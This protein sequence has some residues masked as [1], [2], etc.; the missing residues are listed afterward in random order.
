MSLRRF[1]GPRSI[2]AGSGL[3]GASGEARA[4]GS[5]VG[6]EVGHSDARSDPRLGLRP[7]DGDERLDDLS[8]SRG[9]RRRCPT[10]EGSQRRRYPSMLG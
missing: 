1:V 2:E 7:D 4:R 8:P 10:F 3:R 9:L 5:R 6:R